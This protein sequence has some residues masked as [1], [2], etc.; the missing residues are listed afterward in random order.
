[1]SPVPASL[2]QVER[3]LKIHSRL[4]GADLWLV[5]DHYAGPGLDAPAYSAAECRLLLTL[6]PSPE[7]LRAIHLVKE[8]FAGE[9]VEEGEEAGEL[10]Q[11]H[12]QLLARYGQLEQELEEGRASEAEFLRLARRLSQVMNQLGES[13]A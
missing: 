11:L 13:G 5:P 10:G 6:Q 4:L 12:R 9:L 2:Q 3:P 1:M 8:C 7:E